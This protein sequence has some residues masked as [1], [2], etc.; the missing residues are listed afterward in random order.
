M[1]TIIIIIIC[2]ELVTQENNH[3]L[4]ILVTPG[5]M[6]TRKIF[7]VNSEKKKSVTRS[8]KLTFYNHY[9]RIFPSFNKS[10]LDLLVITIL[11]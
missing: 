5:T 4:I 7:K 6:R 11:S 3:D 2:Y 1:L 9:E 8:E 10:S